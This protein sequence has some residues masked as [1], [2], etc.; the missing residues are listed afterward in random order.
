M[1][2]FDLRLTTAKP[3]N[4][5]RQEL[6]RTL[7][8]PLARWGYEVTSQ[9]DDTVVFT[10]KFRPWYTIF[11]RRTAS[12]VATI[13]TTDDPTKSTLKVAGVGPRKISRAFRSL[14]G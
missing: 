10:R 4:T 2:R 12:I 8:P 11:G 3:P 9:T 5:L 14:E 6:L 7:A 13:E 1:R